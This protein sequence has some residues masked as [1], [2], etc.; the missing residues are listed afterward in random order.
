MC[1]CP[2]KYIAQSVP[3]FTTA[4]LIEQHCFSE[5]LVF[6]WAS[7]VLLNLCSVRFI[8]GIETLLHCKLLLSANLTCLTLTQAKSNQQYCC[9]HTNTHKSPIIYI[10]PAFNIIVTTTLFSHRLEKLGKINKHVPVIEF[11]EAV[12]FLMFLDISSFHVKKR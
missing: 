4:D 6:R 10:L 9:R 11:P 12:G 8:A 1:V 3:I 2:M 5:A 7:F